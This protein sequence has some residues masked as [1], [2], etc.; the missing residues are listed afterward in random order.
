MWKTL[1][2][3]RPRIVIVEYNSVLGA[4]KTLS[5]PYDPDFSIWTAHRSLL[6]FGASLSALCLL[7]RQ[8][9]YQFVGCESHGCNA[10]FVRGDLAHNLPTLTV[11]EGYVPSRFRYGHDA[12][13]WVPVA[14]HRERLALM[15]DVRYEDTVTGDVRTVADI[16]NIS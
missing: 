7:A 6:Y 3:V 5:I 2:V 15:A 12:N 8:K 11:Q 10:F 4:E 1:T 9:G 16:Y 13:G 14:D